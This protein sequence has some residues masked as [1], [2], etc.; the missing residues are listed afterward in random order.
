MRGFC[1]GKGPALAV[2][3]LALGQI[4]TSSLAMAQANRYT[5]SSGT[6]HD[7]KTN[8]T[9]QQASP[10]TTYTLSAASTY[11]QGM[12]TGWRLPT[13]KELLSIVDF[14]IPSPGPTLPPVFS[15]PASFYW[16]STAV[17]GSPPFMWGVNFDYATMG[18][19][20]SDDV[21]VVR[22]VR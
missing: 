2:A 16:S 17:A 13:I 4:W 21:G 12:G 6:V 10:T 15:G 20:G 5:V 18:D 19:H 1:R 14:T 3:A 9:W 22:C 7:N 11:C 8:L